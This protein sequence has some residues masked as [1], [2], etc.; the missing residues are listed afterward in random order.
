MKENK[1]DKAQSKKKMKNQNDKNIT[2]S[3]VN[4]SFNS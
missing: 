4:L 2:K 1:N 3:W